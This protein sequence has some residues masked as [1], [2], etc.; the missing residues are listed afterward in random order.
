MLGKYN[1][2]EYLTYVT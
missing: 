1:Y 2:C